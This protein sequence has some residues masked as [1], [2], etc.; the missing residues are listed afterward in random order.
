MFASSSV[1]RCGLALRRAAGRPARGCAAVAAAVALAL[2]LA[3]SSAA[4]AGKPP[5]PRPTPTRAP[6]DLNADG[7][8][9]DRVVAAGVQTN[10]MTVWDCALPTM[11]PVVSARVEHGSVAIQTGQGPNCGRPSIWLTRVFY[12]SDPGFK[13]TDK[14][15]LLAFFSNGDFDQSYT[16]LVK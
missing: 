14:L 16:I 5:H 7:S 2:V 10:V 11:A 8:V 9:P 6:L 13:G 4:A 15:Y 3:A 12:T 1:V